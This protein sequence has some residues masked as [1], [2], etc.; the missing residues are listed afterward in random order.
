[1]KKFFEALLCATFTRD[2]LPFL[3]YIYIFIFLV[4]VMVAFIM[5]MIGVEHLSDDFISNV[6]TFVGIWIGILTAERGADKW[7]SKFKKIKRKT[8]E[9]AN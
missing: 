9:K 1:M 5:K 2:G 7:F 8:N 6:L 4:L 3:P